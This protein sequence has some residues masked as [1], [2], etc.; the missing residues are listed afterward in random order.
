MVERKSKPQPTGGR[1][2]EPREAKITTRT[3]RQMMRLLEGQNVEL[4]GRGAHQLEDG[5]F[6]AHIIATEEVL[7]RLPKDIGQIEIRP[8]RSVAAAEAKV[9][10]GNRYGKEGTVPHGVGKK[11]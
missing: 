3:A 7:S 6:V 9:G 11:E 5:S 8:K 2:Q 4:V 10:T 1:E